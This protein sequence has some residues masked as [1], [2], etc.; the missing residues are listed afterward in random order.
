MAL[1]HYQAGVVANSIVIGGS[2]KATIA[3][4]SNERQVVSLDMGTLS[5]RNPIYVAGED[6]TMGQGS[7]AITAVADNYNQL[8]TIIN[9]RTYI[10]DIARSARAIGAV[11]TVTGNI[12]SQF[13]GVLAAGTNTRLWIAG[14]GK[15]KLTFGNKEIILALDELAFPFLHGGEVEVLPG[16]ILQY[17]DV[18]NAPLTGGGTAGFNYLP[19]TFVEGGAGS[20]SEA[21]QGVDLISGQGVIR[22]EDET[23]GEQDITLRLNQAEYPVVLDTTQTPIFKGSGIGFGIN[24][25]AVTV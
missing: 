22:V 9:T 5:Q 12:A 1:I 24:L 23:D 2:G 11:Q 13:E 18:S 4:S 8:T 3:N 14:H 15:A 25:Q 20:A 17:T 16:S 10:Q 19:T 21:G 7:A 6:F